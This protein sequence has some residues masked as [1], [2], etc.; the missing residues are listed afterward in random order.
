MRYVVPPN[1]LWSEIL[2]LLCFLCQAIAAFEENRM[3]VT[4]QSKHLLFAAYI[5]SGNVDGAVS[6]LSKFEWEGFSPTIAMRNSLL[7]AIIK[8]PELQ[9][10]T[11]LTNCF[12]YY[13]GVIHKAD[14]ATFQ[15]AL[16][17]CEKYGRVDDA[18][19]W[20]DLLISSG[21]KVTPTVLDILHRTLGDVDFE[22]CKSRLPL[23]IQEM[24]QQQVATVDVD[25]NAVENGVADYMLRRDTESLKAKTV[26]PAFKIKKKWITSMEKMKDL[27]RRGDVAGVQS[28]IDALDAEGSIPR[29]LLL[30]H[31]VYAHM[32]ALNTE[33]AQGVVDLM[34]KKN[35]YVSRKS[36]QHL[37]HSYSNDGDGAEAE[38]VVLEALMSGHATGEWRM[39]IYVHDVYGQLVRDGISASKI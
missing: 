26:A 19:R 38:K 17:A 1:R 30:E 10:E 27:G 22:E 33:G 3:E 5:N 15:L 20:F 6:T 34:K 2:I 23:D 36:Y 7:S 14:S 13:R 9:Y 25:A 29:P 32:K 4:A 11:V 35:I 37:V 39:R 12:E 24:M 8:A 28:L 21:L 16:S 18:K 31:L